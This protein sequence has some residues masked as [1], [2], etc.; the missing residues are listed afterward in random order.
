MAHPSPCI[1]GTWSGTPPF[2]NIN[3]LQINLSGFPLQYIGIIPDNSSELG[4]VW[5]GSFVVSNIES[6]SFITN[7]PGAT[8][9]QTGANPILN[10]YVTD[11]VHL[12]ISFKQLSVNL[13]LVDCQANPLPNPVGDGNSSS[14]QTNI[15]QMAAA[16]K[17]AT[18]SFCTSLN[19][20]KPKGWGN[21]GGAI[22]FCDV[23]VLFYALLA[24]ALGIMAALLASRINM[25]L[26]LPIGGLVF[27]LMMLVG[28]A[29]LPLR[30]WLI[31]I[32]IL[33]LVVSSLITVIL[34]LFP[35][36]FGSGGGGGASG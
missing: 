21:A 19:K 35:M 4:P 9:V 8:A 23:I 1:S 22:N 29:F 12:G 31:L 13:N 33:M 36:G 7:P 14:F 11:S 16:A 30:A 3:P 6:P 24:F 20:F 27:S 2:D 17:Q 10:F 15:T 26:G 25:Y 5:E 18:N 34:L 28:N 32:S